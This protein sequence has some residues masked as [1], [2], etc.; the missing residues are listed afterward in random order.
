MP[1]LRDLEFELPGGAVTALVGPS[2]CGKTTTLRIMLG[3]DRD[4]AGVMTPDLDEMTVGAVFQE[5][6]LLPWRSVEQNVRLAL[7]PGAS[8][9]HFDRLFEAVGLSRMRDRYPAE[10]SL[11]QA[12]RVA[13]A[14]ALAI[15]PSV[16]LLDEPFVSVDESTAD[17]LRNLLLDLWRADP[18]TILI[19]THNL[20]EAVLLADRI[21][22]LSAGPASVVAAIDIPTA[23]E[24]RGRDYLDRIVAEIGRE[25]NDGTAAPPKREDSEPPP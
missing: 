12:R 3:L 25:L 24:D 2:G 1:V 19:V 18:I 9:A 14:R 21:V 20:R 5:P 17:R 16:L 8:P 11:G 15:R 13:L 23:R 4:Y 6:R 7:L 22:V 10:L